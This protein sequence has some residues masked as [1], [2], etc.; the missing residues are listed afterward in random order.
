MAAALRQMRLAPSDGDQ[1]QDDPSHE[2][3]L[4]ETGGENDDSTSRSGGLYTDTMDMTALKKRL[5][6]YIDEKFV[7]L[8]RQLDERFEELTKMVLEQLDT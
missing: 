5:Q 1:R 8:Q 4:N 7:Q 2:A 3:S 6:K